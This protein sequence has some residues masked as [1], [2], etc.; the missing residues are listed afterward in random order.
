MGKERNYLVFYRFDGK[1]VGLSKTGF[2]VQLVV[3]IILLIFAFALLPLV[4]A[5]SSSL[6]IT[7]FILIWWVIGK[8]NA[9]K[10]EGKIN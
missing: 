6:M 4:L 3:L 7:P 8:R 10:L 1:P 5:I 2:F 9:K